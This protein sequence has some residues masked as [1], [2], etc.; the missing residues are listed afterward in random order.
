VL[1]LEVA[2]Q[3]LKTDESKAVTNGYLRTVPGTQGTELAT[4]LHPG[5]HEFS[6]AALP[7]IIEFFK[8]HARP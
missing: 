8:R 1:A 7:L 4:Y 3:V 5:G 2:R 6:Q